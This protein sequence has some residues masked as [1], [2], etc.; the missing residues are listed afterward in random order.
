MAEIIP[1]EEDEQIAFIQWCQI[2]N[3]KCH[4]CANEIGGSTRALKLRA[5]KAKRMGTSKGF[6][7]LLVFI[8]IKGIQKIDA[9]QMLAI[10]MKRKKNSNTSPEQKEWIKILEMAGIPSRVCKGCE[11]AIDF[12]KEYMV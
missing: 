5:I 11:Q 1:K 12:V 10:E 4:H 9:Y 3:I 6:P 7:D 8:P 2:N